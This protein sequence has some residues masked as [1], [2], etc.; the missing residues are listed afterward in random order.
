MS[1]EI[2]TI[3]LNSDP[4]QPI[5]WLI[6]S[7]MRGEA[8]ASGEVDEIKKLT[9]Y[10]NERDV[11]IL[12]DSSVVMLT[13]VVIPKGSEKQLETVLP[14]LLEDEI[15]QDVMQVH[16]SLLS[17]EDDIAN[18]AVI[19]KVL[20]EHWLDLLAE[21]QIIPRRVLPDCLCIPSRQN[22][23]TTAMFQ[24][25]WLVR[26]GETQGGAAEQAWLPVWLQSLSNTSLTE[27]S[28][29]EA[30][31]S[32]ESENAE[33]NSICNQK[34]VISFSPL[35]ANAE[36]HWRYKPTDSVF[37][38][39]AR[40]ASLSRYNLLTGKYKPQ[41]QLINNLKP[42]RGAAIAAGILCVIFAVENVISIYQMEAQIAVYKEQTRQDVLDMFP[43]NKRI[44]TTS[45]MKR[46]FTKEIS[47]LTGV[48]SSV[49]FMA[50]MSELAPLI[51][52]V[53][54]TKLESIR[55]DKSRSELRLTMQGK[56]FSDFEKLREHF[57]AKFKT[58]LGQLNRTQN[59]VTGAFVLEKKSS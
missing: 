58:E 27:E 40:L 24:D 3:R 39:M 10:C 5:A 56:D 59:S 51:K 48:N 16:V 13:S 45:Y 54:N 32:K 57:S 37:K 35:P 19:E 21:H 2:L 11:I 47:E 25:K 36:P 50:W 28:Q 33:E 34:D 53:S 55:F 44:P 8:I 52:E 15:A 49:N 38:E 30:A 46:L 7:P 17:K 9:N 20:L 6:W 43:D 26:S 12:I 14:Y 18:V 31:D 1:S 29:S 23:I 42:W 22:S 41:S 4:S